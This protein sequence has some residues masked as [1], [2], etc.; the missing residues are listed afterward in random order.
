MQLQS[1]V[2]DI[3]AAKVTSFDFTG[4]IIMV[5]IDRLKYKSYIIEKLDYNREKGRHEFRVIINGP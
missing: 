3:L 2:D 1:K 5:V 4:G